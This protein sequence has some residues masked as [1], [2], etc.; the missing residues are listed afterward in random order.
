MSRTEK[1]SESSSDLVAT[2]QSVPSP[3]STEEQGDAFEDAVMSLQ[4]L[5]SHKRE[6][7]T[8]LLACKELIRVVD[9]TVASSKGK[10]FEDE[11]LFALKV[12]G[13]SGTS[14][15]TACILRSVRAK[16]APD[17]FLW[18]VA[19]VPFG[20]GHPEAASFFKA[21][22][23][24]LP[25]RFLGVCVLDAANSACRDHKLK[26]HPFDSA[27]G[28]KKLARH[29]SATKASEFSYAVSACA[30]LPF[31]S[32]SRR[33]PLLVK[34]L[35]HKDPSIRMEVAWAIAKAD[36]KRGLDYLVEKCLDRNMSCQAIAY[37]KE[38]GKGR[39]VPKAARDP[40]FAAMAEMCDW[41]RH[42]NEAGRPPDRIELKDKRT[43]YWPPTRDTRQVHLF[44][45]VFEKD[46]RSSERTAGVGMVGSMTWSFFDDTKPSMKPEDIY[47]HHCCIEL[48]YQDDPRA[49]KKRSAKAGWALI[50]GRK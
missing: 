15:G 38:I 49:P 46:S 23:K 7:K 13:F 3:L 16:F 18:S 30:A 2:L 36:D 43:I 21:V 48:E 42:P 28:V 45:F 31:I 4:G 9:A 11:V 41:L 33:K 22:G 34:A 17:G 26:T 19:L 5:L 27:S 24:A 20:N 37:L 50:T 6:R 1:K 29:L 47:G 44:N 39:L 25:E 40:D 10:R 35:A 12:L 14:E 8:V 32:P